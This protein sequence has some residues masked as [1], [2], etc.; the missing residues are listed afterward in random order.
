MTSLCWYDDGEHVVLGP[1]V[2]QDTT[3]KIKMIHEKIITFQRNQNSYHDKRRKAFEFQ[4][5]DHVF[6]RVTLVTSV[7]RALKSPKVTPHLIGPYQ[8]MQKVGKVSYMIALPPSLLNLHEVF[9]VSQLR[10]YIP[11]PSHVIQVDDVLVRENLTAEASSLRLE[12][13]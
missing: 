6:L 8:T 2:V 7:G 4:K 13:R 1:Q 11:D 5:G 9:H 3:E 10:R 12:D